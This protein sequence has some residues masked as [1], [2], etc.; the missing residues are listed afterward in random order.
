MNVKS[1]IVG[2]LL[3][4][5]NVAFAGSGKAIIPM[6][7]AVANGKH[8]TDVRLSNITSNN[9]EVKVTFY[10]TDGTKVTSG[11]TYWDF[12]NGNTQLS[13]NSSGRLRIDTAGYGYATIEW[14][15]VGETDDDVVAI[16]AHGERFL[17]QSG[18]IGVTSLPVNQGLPF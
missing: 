3:L 9:I 13:P 7:H 17:I 4:V 11:I 12:I 16:I 15:N 6:W 18:G 5:S 1:L 8:F 10:N 2:C 14:N